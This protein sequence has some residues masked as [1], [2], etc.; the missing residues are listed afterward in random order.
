MS[1]KT[2]N[3]AV[4]KLRFP[5][6]RDEQAWREETLAENLHEHKLKSDGK[7]EVY[8]V[9]VHKGVINQVEHLGRSFA[10]ANTFNYSLVKPFDVIYTKSP[11]G[12]FPYG[13][14]KQNL[15]GRTV[16]VSPLYGVFAPVNQHLGYLIH[17]YFEHRSRLNNYLVSLVQK[18]A[19]NT[20][21]ISNDR[22]LSKGIYLPHNEKEQQKIASF[23]SSVN[24]LLTTQIDKLTALKA[25]KQSLMQGLFPAEGE[26][27][28]KL[29]FSE[30]QEAGDWVEKK[31]GEL[32]DFTRGP[33]GG[34]LKKDFFVED[35][36]AVYEQSHAIHK[37]FNSFRYYINEEKFAGLR[38]FSVLPN[39]IIMSCSGTMG[40]FA[41][42]PPEAKK[43][44]INQA[45]LKLRV[46]K[47]FNL[48]FIQTS[49]ELPS[50][51]HKLL[52][53][54]AG[55]AIQN[56]VEVKQIKEIP[57]FLPS[58]VEQQ[59]ITATLSSLDDCIAAQSQKIDALKLHKEGLMQGLFP[60]VTEPTV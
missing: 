56:V 41:I 28:P 15:T 59:K 4:P 60:A 13:I 14:V 24:D 23:I 19:K 3:T 22:F 50:T 38:R 48:N 58:L 17:A 37:N 35:G 6:F 57:F 49:L 18:G 21:Q 43:G 30:F 39:D 44:V 1:N 32:C 36:Y 33:F 2:T 26:T 46:K 55:G 10:A 45:L 12:D 8:S 5:E 54:S 52:S 53:Q 25:H 31:L 40:K 29:R 9:S 7:S 42:I 51:Q 34:A 11:T 27:V 16:L 47:D 20:I